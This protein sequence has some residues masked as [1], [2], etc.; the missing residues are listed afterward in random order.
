MVKNRGMLKNHR[1]IFVRQKNRPVRPCVSPSVVAL[2]LRT[3]N[4]PLR[5]SKK[6]Q[7][8]L[9]PP[10]GETDKDGPAGTSSPHHPGLLGDDKGTEFLVE[11][12]D[13][14]SAELQ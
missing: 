5:T 11:A 1:S 14:A 2:S 10:H 13:P 4:K 12:W 3:S 9:L 8:I 6:A 7:P